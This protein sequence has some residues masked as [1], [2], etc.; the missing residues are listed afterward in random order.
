LSTLTGAV[1]SVAGGMTMNLMSGLPPGGTFP[2]VYHNSAVYFGNAL[3]SVA[4]IMPVEAIITCLTLALTV[5]MTLWGFHV[6]R[7]VANFVRGIPT[8]NYNG[9]MLPDESPRSAA[10]DARGRFD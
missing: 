10:S 8:S 2:A 1:G 9:Y 7:W 3:Q 5:K 4:F 6:A